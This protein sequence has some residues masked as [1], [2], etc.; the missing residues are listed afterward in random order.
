MQT[1]SGVSACR[2]PKGQTVEHRLHFPSSR[3]RSP[4][5][6][7]LRIGHHLSI[8]LKCNFPI[9]RLP[10]KFPVETQEWRSRAEKQQNQAKRKEV[11]GFLTIHAEEPGTLQEVPHPFRKGQEQDQGERER[12]EREKSMSPSLV[13]MTDCQGLL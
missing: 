11:A 3:P 9:H 7:N 12:L 13:V 10:L 8:F 4:E 2:F 6:R 5:P 1:R